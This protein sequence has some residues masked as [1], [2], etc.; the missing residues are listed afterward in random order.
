LLNLIALLDQI[1]E[2][3]ARLERLD[4]RTLAV[5]ALKATTTAGIITAQL[6]LALVSDHTERR[7]PR[8]PRET[9]PDLLTV[10]EAAGVLRYGLSHVYDLVHSGELAAVACGRSIRIRRSAVDAFIATHERSS[11]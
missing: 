6:Q 5:L 7:G 4:V 11:R 1:T 10:K 3:P 2:D 8:G 9:A